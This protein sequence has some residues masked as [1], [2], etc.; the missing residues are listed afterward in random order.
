MAESGR[1]TPLF[2]W[3]RIYSR[4]A[5]QLPQSELQGE[6][7]VRSAIEIALTEVEP[8]SWLNPGAGRRFSCGG[9]FIREGQRS[10]PNQSCRA[11]LRSA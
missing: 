10:C 1:G 3:E 5:A 9:E 7:S 2:L 4:R 8:S 6:P 11:H